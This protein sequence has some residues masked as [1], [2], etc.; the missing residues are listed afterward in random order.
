MLSRLRSAWH[1]HRIQR[2]LRRKAI[3]EDLWRLTV[4]RLPFLQRR[5]SAEL[6]E[7]RRLASLFLDQKQFTG[8]GLV[9]TDEIA[10]AVATQ[11]CLPVLRLGLEPYAGF[12]GLVIH[13]DE[14]LAER[15][16]ADDDGVVHH[17]QE[18]LTGEAMEGGP[19]MLT[20]ADVRDAGE[21]AEQ[22]Y[23]VVIHEFAHVIDM[24][25]GF[26]DGVPILYGAGA[27]SEWRAALASEYERFCDCVDRD[28]PTVLDPYGA[29]APAEFFAVAVEAFF[30]NAEA[31][32]KEQPVMYQLLSSFF[33]QDPAASTAG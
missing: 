11:A 31:M 22:G 1:E 21:L 17:Y 20:W 26:A 8:V 33:N 32:K 29:T 16:T 5:S 3:P 12:V 28:E 25:N 13:Q 2:A 4:S 7:L 14:V 27:R 19:V 15:V 30:V 6:N 10:V 23:N 24:R 9:I 18:A